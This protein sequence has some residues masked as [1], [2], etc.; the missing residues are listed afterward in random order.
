MQRLYNI[1]PMP[2]GNRPAYFV[3][4]TSRALYPP[5][6]PNGYWDSDASPAGWLKSRKN[7][8]VL[9]AGL[10]ILAP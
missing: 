1:L 3:S 9:S 8:C 4:N 6:E 2:L 7:V 10:Y 5:S